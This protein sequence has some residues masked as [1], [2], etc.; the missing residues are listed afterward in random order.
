VVEGI[1]KIIIVKAKVKIEHTAAFPPFSS[2]LMPHFA[3]NGCV[4]ATTPFVL[5]TTL[6]LL[7]NVHVP[8]SGAVAN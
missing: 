3:A 1:E 5:C 4:Q 7:A 6:L 8:L 2:T